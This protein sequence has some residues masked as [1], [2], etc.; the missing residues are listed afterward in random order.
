MT[1]EEIDKVFERYSLANIFRDVE[2]YWYAQI[3]DKEHP[4]PILP[5]DISWLSIE[6]GIKS[7][8]LGTILVYHM[9]DTNF[10][11][12]RTEKGWEL[13]ND[14]SLADLFALMAWPNLPGQ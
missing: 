10:A 8:Q 14:Q 11:T 12:E 3:M 13:I 5:N 1:Q 2:G 7:R 9:H 4:V 6:V